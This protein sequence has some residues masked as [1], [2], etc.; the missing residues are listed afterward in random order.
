MILF[1]HKSVLKFFIKD[2]HILIIVFDLKVYA[3]LLILKWIKALDEQSHDVRE[4]YSLL[5]SQ[6][7][8]EC[9]V[10]YKV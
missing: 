4:I 9:L 5:C 6:H 3:F 8:E 7:E 10:Y 2:K 1:P